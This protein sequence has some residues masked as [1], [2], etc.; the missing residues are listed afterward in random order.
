MPRLLKNYYLLLLFCLS[1]CFQ[2]YGQQTAST[3]LL[4]DLH[5][6]RNRGVLLM[7]VSGYEVVV[8]RANGSLGKPYLKHQFPAFDLKPFTHI[9]TD[10]VSGIRMYRVDRKLWQPGTP[11]LYNTCLFAASNNATVVGISIIGS[12][13]PGLAWRRPWCN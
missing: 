6:L 11:V 7:N 13:R 2:C 9:V 12:N 8:A 1:A 5:V 10:S 4:S 3:D